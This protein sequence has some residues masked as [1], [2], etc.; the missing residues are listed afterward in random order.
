[1][2]LL[3]LRKKE[4]GSLGVISERQNKDEVQRDSENKN[5]TCV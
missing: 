5:V 4:G 3:E 1:M 2:K